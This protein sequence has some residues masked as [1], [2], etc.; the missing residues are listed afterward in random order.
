MKELLDNLVERFE[1]PDFIQ[2]DPV[3]YIH[4]FETVPQIEVAGFVSSI[5]AYGKREL[6]LK[7]LDEFF[8]CPLDVK[9]FDTER[10]SDFSYRFSKGVDFVQV[11]K[12]LENIYSQNESLGSLFSL[13]YSRTGS[14]SGMLCEVCNYF[15]KN[16]TLDV[17][18][19]FYSLIPN[20]ANGS[21][22]KR[23]NMMLRWFVRKSCVD[24][25]I[26]HFIPKSEL[27]I[28]LDVHVARTSRKLGLLTRNADDFKSAVEITSRLKEFDPEDPVKYDFAL[29]GA[30]IEGVLPEKLPAQIS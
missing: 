9:N 7:K 30:G 22:M 8:A 23:M 12:I 29:F 6:F 11:L 16:V 3:R 17:T 20:P 18:R 26:W 15:Y 13:A 28:P 27:V 2:S 10:F 5:F 25:G 21:A 4:R 19:G 1:T 24:R 14:I